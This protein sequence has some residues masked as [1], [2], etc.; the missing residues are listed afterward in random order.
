MRRDENSSQPRRSSRLQRWLFAGLGVACVGVGAVGAFVPGLPT[1]V[2]LLMA[3]WLFARS[4]PWLEDRLV[5]VPLFRPFLVHV[6]P[7]APMP[8]R[9]VVTTLVIMWGAIALSAALLLL[10]GEPRPVIAAVVVTAGVAGTA[11]LISMNRRNTASRRA[12]TADTAPGCGLTPPT[13]RSSGSRERVSPA[14]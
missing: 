4:C 2:F 8:R 12:R 10:A 1:T 13:S 5:R 7:G 9:A 14:A 6:Q 11:V 3:S